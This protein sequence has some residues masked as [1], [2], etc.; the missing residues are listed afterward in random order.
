MTKQ[1]TILEQT[2][3]RGLDYLCSILTNTGVSAERVEKIKTATLERLATGTGGLL[4]LEQH[5]FNTLA[6][7]P[8]YS[9]YDDDLYVAETY[10]CWTTYSQKYC[11]MLSSST[12]HLPNGLINELGKVDTV[13]D[14]GN[15]HGFS[16]AALKLL[17]PDSRII[18][19]NLPNNLQ[20]T[21]AEVLAAEH[22]FE[23]LPAIPT[24]PAS[25]VFASEYFEHFYEP[26]KHLREVI[27]NLTPD[28]L[29]VANAFGQIGTGHFHEYL[30][31]G[32]LINGKETSKA[33][34]KVL[35]S[36]GYEKLTTGFWNNRPT[37]WYKR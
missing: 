23:L 11:K 14:L 28:F 26:I 3:K 7:A 31:D 32:L 10:V 36:K 19:T 20:W 24:T 6:T 17:F 8:D 30:V 27:T 22:K 37:V 21:V 35:R 12:K 18:G 1:L 13:V 34:A 4:T 16:T 33:F 5:W 15:G 2:G 9:V 25:I 29:I